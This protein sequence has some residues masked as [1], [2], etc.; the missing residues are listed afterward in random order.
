MAATPGYSE[1]PWAR[2]RALVAEYYDE[3]V[4]RASREALEEPPNALLLFL[5]GRRTAVNAKLER[6][7]DTLLG[8]YAW[9]IFACFFEAVEPVAKPFDFRGLLRG[10]PYTVKAVS[11]ER[12]FN[13]A[14]RARVE[15][16]SLSLENPVVLTLQ[17]P[18]FEAREVG[19]ALWLSAPASWRLLAGPGGYKRFLA[20]AREEAK[21]RRALV[22]ERVLRAVADAQ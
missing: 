15:D 2:V 4:E 6:I 8:S 21:A 10:R 18:Y 12:A 19:R 9:R 14:T 22:V 11:G 13:T 1:T 7:A 5:A 20:V 16:A 17:G 3:V